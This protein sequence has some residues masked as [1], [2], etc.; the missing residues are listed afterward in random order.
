MAPIQRKGLVAL[1][2]W[3]KRVTTEYPNVSITDLSSSFRDG[4]AFNAIIHHFRPHL[5]D[6]YSLKP[7][8]VLG[9]NAHAF[10]VAEEQLNIPALLD[11]EDMVETE[12]PDKKS[13]ALYLAQFYHMFKEEEK[14]STSSPNIS[15]N[16]LSESS[17]EN[18]SIVQSFSEGSES[19]EGTPSATPT[20]TRT[21]RLFNRGDLLEK[22][23]EDIFSNGKDDNDES[24]KFGRKS[25]LW[26]K[27]NT[28]N[29]KD[30]EVTRKVQPTSPSVASMCK[31]FELNAKISAS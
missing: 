24:N 4:L 28:Q 16:R 22:Y 10:K 21:S 14:S 6:Y 2:L 18:D 30:T 20:T 11:P 5:F 15:L 3:C 27:Q 9:N 19:S 17:N 23:G 12:D 31:H 26:T 7:N 1:Q 13:V 25:Q 29:K 8:D